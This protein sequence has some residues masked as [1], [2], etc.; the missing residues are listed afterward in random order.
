MTCFLLYLI[1]REGQFWANGCLHTVAGLLLHLS[2]PITKSCSHI[3]ILW[4][5]FPR[6]V[7]KQSKVRFVTNYLSIE[8]NMKVSKIIGPFRSSCAADISRYFHL[9]M[10]MNT[11]ER[12]NALADWL[13]YLRKIQEKDLEQVFLLLLIA[14]DLI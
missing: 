13:Q 8:R 3:F 2:Q 4:S 6:S 5:F 10:S 12:N 7:L 14:M 1:V 9:F 11:K